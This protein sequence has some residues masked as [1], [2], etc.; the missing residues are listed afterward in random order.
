MNEKNQMT[1]DPPQ[2]LKVLQ[3]KWLRLPS[4]PALSVKSLWTQATQKQRDKA[5]E[6]AILL[7]QYWLNQMSK[8]EVAKA[9][10]VP[11]IRVWQLSQQAV[12]GMAAGLLPQPKLNPKDD[13]KLLRKKI[14]QLQLAL[15][16]QQQLIRI[17]RELPGVEH[18][19]RKKIQAQLQRRRKRNAHPT[20]A[21]PEA[22][23]NESGI[24][25]V[26]AEGQQGGELTPS[27]HKPGDQ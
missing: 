4:K 8:E 1:G 14:E 10:K 19:A 15:A 23:H 22:I 21:V 17:I 27:S 3:S 7:I 11:P 26:I 18:R 12:S 25:S 16:A 13:P 6:T 24:T 2:K 20:T 5:H 9:L